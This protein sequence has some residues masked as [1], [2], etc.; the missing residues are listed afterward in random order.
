M[1]KDFRFDN[2]MIGALRGASRRYPPF[3]KKANNSKEVYYI[4]TKT[5]KRLRRVKIQCALCKQYYSQ[6]DMRK[7]HIEPLIPVTGMPRQE[8]GD[9]DWNIII[10]RM[11]CSPD[12]IQIICEGCHAVKSD[13]EKTLR[14]LNE[15]LFTPENFYKLW[16]YSVVKR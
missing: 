2:W 13:G 16:W 7:D 3:Y 10:P 14:M 8:S 6:K 1:A 5:G 12:N 15:I 9:I 11:F 4:P